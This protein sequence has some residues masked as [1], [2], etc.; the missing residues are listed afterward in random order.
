M[1]DPILLKLKKVV[2][3]SWV[4][5]TAYPIT[6]PIDLTLVKGYT[7]YKNT[8]V[9]SFLTDSTALGGEL[10]VLN[11]FTISKASWTS[12]TSVAYRDFTDDVSNFLRWGDDNTLWLTLTADGYDYIKSEIATADLAVAG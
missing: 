11:D 6:Y 12:A 5:S 1:F 8:F 4:D 10:Y 7:L 3:G 9:L 2:G